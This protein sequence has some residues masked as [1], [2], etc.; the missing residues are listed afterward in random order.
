M[1]RGRCALLEAVFVK[2]STLQVLIAEDDRVSRRILQSTLAKWGYDVVV[3]R[4]GDQ[5]W[6]VLQRPDAPSLAIVD[7]MMPGLD[8]LELCRRVR[9]RHEPSRSYTY[10]ILLT[11]NSQREDIITGM[12]A[13]A[14]DYVTKPFDSGE[15]RARLRAA[16]RVL[17]LEA[18]LLQSQQ[19]LQHQANHDSLTG[20][21][22]R[23][24]ILGI[25]V[26]ELTRAQREGKPVAV[27]LADIDYF[28]RI[29]DTHG[30]EAG[31]VALRETARTMQAAMRPYDTIG[32]YGG[33]EFLIVMPGCD[34]PTAAQRAEGIRRSVGKAEIIAAGQ[35]ISLTVCMGVTAWH[36][37]SPVST[38]T[39]I[40]A[41]DAA[42]YSAKR[43]GRNR[44]VMTV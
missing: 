23:S 22:N 17:D 15:L 40:Q 39:L 16:Q 8:G 11:G 7:W 30:H 28:K 19:A 1:G 18:Q 34:E 36:E 10:I 43:S 37:G 44:V 42:M 24:A 9:E 14:D 25:L 2:E 32:R 4:D 35:A 38:D 26:K 29:N 31:D 41:A 13:G 21:L 12:D 5:A 20:L 3:T 33:E 6:S 27:I